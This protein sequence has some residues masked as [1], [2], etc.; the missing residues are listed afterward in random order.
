MDRAI[1]TR[2]F[3]LRVHREEERKEREKITERFLSRICYP[4]GWAGRGKRGIER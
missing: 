2:I 3:H 1:E 4:R